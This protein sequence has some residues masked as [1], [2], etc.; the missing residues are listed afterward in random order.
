MLTFKNINTLTV[1][2]LIGVLICDFFI[3][4]LPALFYVMLAVVWLFFTVVGSFNIRWSYHLKVYNK[5]N[6][7]T[8]K[9]VVITFDDGPSN[10]YTLEVLSLLKKYNA[11]AT[12]FCIGKNI[13]QYPEIVKRIDAEGHIIGNHS[14][15]HS[16]FFGFYGARKVIGE[17]K[18]TD[19]LIKNNIDKKV[20]FFR[21]PF[22]VTNPSIA[23]AVKKTEHLTIGWNIRSLDT[24]IKDDKA[25][26]NRITKRIAPGAII[27]LHDSHERILPVLEQ[28]LIFLQNNN[29]Q[30]ISLETLLNHKEYA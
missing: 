12:F 15:S 8:E 9:K 19:E 3:L 20:K 10:K 21:P 17:I 2:L 29:Y 27:L 7:I 24:V 18:K 6:V 1:L 26:L 25:I 5:R 14:Y 22:G 30:T 16:D 11:T 28:L 13:E 23:K 4:L